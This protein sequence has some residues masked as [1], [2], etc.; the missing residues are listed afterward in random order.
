MARLPPGY[1]YALAPLGNFLRTL[2]LPRNYLMLFCN[3][4]PWL[5]L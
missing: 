4:P 2:L 5:F 3:V 1:S